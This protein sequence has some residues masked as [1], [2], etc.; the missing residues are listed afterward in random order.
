MVLSLVG[1]ILFVPVSLSVGKVMV[2]LCWG[3]ARVCLSVGWVKG[4]MGIFLAG[5]VLLARHQRFCWRIC[6]IHH[7]GGYFQR[8]PCK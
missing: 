3:G 7:L 8:I 1:Y 4:G 5:G 2:S 6:C